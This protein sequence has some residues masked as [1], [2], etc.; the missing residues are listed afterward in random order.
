M[1]VVVRLLVVARS[2]LPRPLSQ[3]PQCR[4]RTAWTIS[5]ALG[6]DLASATSNRVKNEIVVGDGDGVNSLASA[7]CT[8]RSQGGRGERGCRLSPR[9][10]GAMEPRAAVGSLLPLAKRRQVLAAILVARAKP[11][12]PEPEQLASNRRLRRT[13]LG[14]GSSCSVTAAEAPPPSDACGDVATHHALQ[15]MLERHTGELAALIDPLAWLR[16]QARHTSEFE[17]FHQAGGKLGPAPAEAAEDARKLAAELTTAL[18]Y[19]G[20]AYGVA[21]ADGHMDSVLRTTYMWTARP[22]VTGVDV[23]ST[24]AATQDRAVRAQIGAAGELL[25]SDWSGGVFRPTHFVAYDPGRNW[26]VLAVRGTLRPD[27]LL[28]DACATPCPFESGLAHE[29]VSRAAQYVVN[30]AA[31]VLAAAVARR[32]GCEI[33]L[34]GH[35]MGAATATLAASLLRSLGLRKQPGATVSAAFSRARCIAFAPLP[36]LSQDLAAS[37]DQ[38]RHT[39]SVVCGADFAP[40]LSMPALSQLREELCGAGIPA[41]LGRG[42][43]RL[44]RMMDVGGMR[45]PSPP[46]D[47]AATGRVAGDPERLQMGG[48][49]LYLQSSAKQP[50]RHGEADLSSQAAALNRV[51]CWATPEAFE[52][53]WL[54]DGCL[55]DHLVS[56]YQ[57]ALAAFAESASQ[58]E[59][60]HQRAKSQ[61]LGK[62]IVMQDIADALQAGSTYDEFKAKY[63]P[64]G[65]TQRLSELWLQSAAAVDSDS[66]SLWSDSEEDDALR[67]THERIHSSADGEKVARL[68]ALLDPSEAA[69]FPRG[70]RQLEAAAAAAVPIKHRAPSGIGP[71]PSASSINTTGTGAAAPIIDGREQLSMQLPM[72]PDP[73]AHALASNGA[74]DD[75][76]SES[77]QLAAENSSDTVGRWLEG[78]QSLAISTGRWD[79]WDPSTGRLHMA[80]VFAEGDATEMFA[81]VSMM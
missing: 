40:R 62:A 80:Q 34:T 54:T 55:S 12:E 23:R 48:R 59:A 22:L 81:P 11:L 64:V 50:S 58:H 37:E 71:V 77:E 79:D 17:A 28:T 66:A 26:L 6:L 39:L 36:V 47:D 56:R 8:S 7:P 65:G 1:E 25:H 42:V 72:L 67:P 63:R 49:V 21:M 27:D 35:S 70:L 32:P 19:A 10:S 41:T 69:G 51:G 45:P 68:K 44:R 3:Q 60:W 73:P 75:E 15:A 61:Q 24:C 29:G 78:I 33:V 18:R 57:N 74:A 76:A 4:V 14:L 13:A 31:G 46:R 52:R 2:T 43:R 16:L 30:Q 53:L 38:Q 5:A 9:P 20:A